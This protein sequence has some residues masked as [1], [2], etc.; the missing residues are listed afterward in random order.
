MNIWAL[1][2]L[3][4]CLSVPNKNMEVFGHPWQNYMN[5]IE[6]N[7]ESFVN[8]NDL[9]LLPGDICWAHKLQDALIDLTWIDRLPGT[10]VMLKGNHDYWWPSNKQLQENLP[11]SM[12]FIN[13]NVFNWGNVSIG[14]SRLWD[15]SEYNFDAIVETVDNPL[16]RK[17]TQEEL[18]KE[19]NQSSKIFDRELIRLKL[20]L[21]QLDQSAHLRIAMTHYPPI[22]HDLRDSLASKLLEEYHVNICIFGH[23][24]NVKKDCPIFGE[25]NQIFY[26]LT[27]ADYLEF[28]P[29]RLR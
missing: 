28:N 23:L 10:K 20:S 18:I 11:P 6:K 13:N 8:P 15:T 2:D 14:G 27:S 16:I 25:K 26:A 7:W 17:K 4:L 9:V 12:H 3:H 19:K 5:R 29:L 1:A 24:H 22:S 21:E